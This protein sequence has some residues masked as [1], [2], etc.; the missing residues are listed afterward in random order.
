M[1]KEKKSGS[2][3]QTWATFLKN[4]ASD[5]WACDFTVV[6]DWLFR[7]WYIFVV[8]ELKT[9]RII[10]TG[11]TKYPTDEWTGQQLREATPWG[12]GP[13]YLIRDRD[14]KYATH[15]SAVAGSIKEVET[16]YR[17]P[18]ANGVCE[19]FMGSLRRECTDHI[20]IHEGRHLERVVKEYTAYFN[21]ERPH[22]G[23]EQRIPDQYDLTRS[24]PTSGRITSKAILGGLHH[25]YSRAIYLN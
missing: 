2:S 22:Q 12:K 1:A 23:I 7:P 13:K 10:H 25:S 11:V 14:S 17:T 20:L 9:R 5:I 19:R 4:Q 21:Q 8:M 6:N 15:F 24:K 18:Q 16:L 3:S